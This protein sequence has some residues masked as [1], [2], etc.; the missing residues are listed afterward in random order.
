MKK[1][2]KKGTIL[3][4]RKIKLD[5]KINFEEIRE[6]MQKDIALKIASCKKQNH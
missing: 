3:D 1:I 2:I 4:A 6:S 5:R